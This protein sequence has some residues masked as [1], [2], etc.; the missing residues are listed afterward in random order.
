MQTTEDTDCGI[1]LNIMILFIVRNR[2]L[3]YT[4]PSIRQPNVF[5]P[6]VVAS[7]ISVGSTVLSSSQ[8]QQQTNRNRN[9]SFFITTKNDSL[10]RKVR[11]TVRNNRYRLSGSPHPNP[12]Y[13]TSP[14]K[15]RNWMPASS[16]W[17]KLPNDLTENT[18]PRET[19]Y[20]QT[21][22]W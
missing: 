14:N 4:Q 1:N 2:P 9:N 21:Y 16:P 20:L 8:A 6:V 18:H 10:N 12:H 7:G 19:S 17:Q 13:D 3:A 15:T 22:S 5:A 11:I